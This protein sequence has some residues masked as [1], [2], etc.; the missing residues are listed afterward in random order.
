MDGTRLCVRWLF[1]VAFLFAG[2][3]SGQEFLIPEDGMECAGAASDGAHLA[4]ALLYGIRSPATA[5]G[6]SAMVHDAPELALVLFDRSISSAGLAP[7]SDMRRLESRSRR[8]V[9]PGFVDVVAAGVA[10]D[11][12]DAERLTT[13][14]ADGFE[15]LVEATTEVSH[16]GH[17]ALVLGSRLVRT[18]TQ[19][20]PTVMNQ[21]LVQLEQVE[22]EKVGVEGYPALIAAVYDIAGI[23]KL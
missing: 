6:F 2:T 1:A 5:T 4:G 12:A 8:L 17:A 13:A 18:G 14:L 23:E 20:A 22:D 7:S 15:L 16:G 9:A 10:I 19:E 21:Y 3:A 11:A